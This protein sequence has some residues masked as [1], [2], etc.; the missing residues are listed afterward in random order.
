MKVLDRPVTKDDAV[1]GVELAFLLL[2]GLI[3]FSH[4][5]A[6][7]RMNPGYIRSIVDRD[8]AE[9]TPRIRSTPGIR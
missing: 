8:S 2:R 6:V 5:P 1:L 9:P 4:S 3:R 7:I